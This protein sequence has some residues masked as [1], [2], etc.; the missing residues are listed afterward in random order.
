MI[1]VKPSDI[2][3]GLRPAP[4]QNGLD[5]HAC[6][7]SIAQVCPA[8]FKLG[9]KIKRGAITSE[10]VGRESANILRVFTV[11]LSHMHRFV[12]SFV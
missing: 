3:L 6:S 9:A 5:S 11:K 12:R 1:P 4:S 10:S 2:Q 7:N 8:N